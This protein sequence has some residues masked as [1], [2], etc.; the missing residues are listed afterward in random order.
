MTLSNWLNPSI[1]F[2]F[3]ILVFKPILDLPYL[4]KVSTKTISSDFTYKVSGLWPTVSAL[5]ES[6]L[7]LVC[8]LPVHLIL[9]LYQSCSIV[10]ISKHYNPLCSSFQSVC[11][12]LAFFLNKSVP[13][14]F[15]VT[16]SQHTLP[17]HAIRACHSLKIL[18]S[19]HVCLGSWELI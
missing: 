11:M 1:V 19:P 6:Q 7:I 8:I 4:K 3:S 12:C 5:L 17:V 16:V 18:Q 2:P 13:L 9:S 10:G 15:T 14:F